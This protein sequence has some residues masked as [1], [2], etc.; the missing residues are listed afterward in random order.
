M[1]KGTGKTGSNGSGKKRTSKTSGASRRGNSM[2]SLFS[3]NNGSN[4]PF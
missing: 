3:R 1:A 4:T 2:Q